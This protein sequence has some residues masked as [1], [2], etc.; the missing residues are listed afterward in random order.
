M[1]NLH[2]NANSYDMNRHSNHIFS[3]TQPH[4]LKRQRSHSKFFLPDEDLLRENHQFSSLRS[5]S[6]DENAKNAANNYRSDFKLSII[7]LTVCTKCSNDS[8]LP[9]KTFQKERTNWV[10]PSDSR[11]SKNG[12]KFNF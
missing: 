11:K 3:L 8:S 7:S 1:Q 9:G 5:N 2:K 10:L 6:D 4:S 12:K